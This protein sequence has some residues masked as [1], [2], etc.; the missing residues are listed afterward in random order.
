MYFEVPGQGSPNTEEL[1]SNW[2]L[3]LE[4]Q[5]EMGSRKK[6]VNFKSGLLSIFNVI[7]GSKK[8]TSV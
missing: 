4:S 2:H 5:L 7:Q 6:V 3:D 1:T 8:L